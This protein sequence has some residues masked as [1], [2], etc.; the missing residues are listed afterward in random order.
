MSSRE[1]CPGE[2]PRV[3]VF[4][5]EKSPCIQ[6]WKQEKAWCVWTPG[7]PLASMASGYSGWRGEAG[8]EGAGKVIRDNRKLLVA[9]TTLGYEVMSRNLTSA[10]FLF[11]CMWT[12]MSDALL[13]SP[14]PYACPRANSSPF[15]FCIVQSNLS[16]LFLAAL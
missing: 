3:E 8:R 4:P 15:F 16:D 6:T 7:S 2:S 12:S 10:G 1:N 13:A 9:V 14:P 11:P 5:A